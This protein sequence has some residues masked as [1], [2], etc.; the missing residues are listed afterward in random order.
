MTTFFKINVSNK[1]KKLRRRKASNFKGE[2]PDYSINRVNVRCCS[3][4]GS[5]VFTFRWFMKHLN[6]RLYIYESNLFTKNIP[7]RSSSL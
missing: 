7:L 3:L 4:R 2:I 6:D 1:N 5:D